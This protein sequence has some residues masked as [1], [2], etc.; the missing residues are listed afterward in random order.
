MDR[1][2]KGQMTV[3]NLAGLFVAFI[4][5]LALMPVLNSFI[6][7]TVTT[8]QSGTQTDF[9]SMIITVLHLTPFAI[10][11]MLIV[12]GFYFAMPRQQGY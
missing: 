7:T 1:Y 3:I 2:M 6:D 10:L 9:T 11:V 12:T 4:M 5:Y 8:L